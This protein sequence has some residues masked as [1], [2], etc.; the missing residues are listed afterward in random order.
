VDINTGL[1]PS[2]DQILSDTFGVP[3]PNGRFAGTF[4][5]S[6]MAV[7]YFA[8]DADHGFFVETDLVDPGTGQVALGYYAR[9]VPVCDGC[10]GVR[11]RA[12]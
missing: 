9:R 5:N 10:P 7:D 6:T 3:D 8:I 11:P 12:R 1:S 4:L 2:L